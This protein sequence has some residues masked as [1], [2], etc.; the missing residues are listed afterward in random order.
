[1]VVSKTMGKRKNFSKTNH[2]LEIKPPPVN[3]LF[4]EQGQESCFTLCYHKKKEEAR[5]SSK[6]LS[7]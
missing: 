1:M 3:S 6:L 5:A 4:F 7:D 2:T